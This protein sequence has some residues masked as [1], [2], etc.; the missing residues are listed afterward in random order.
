MTTRK[1]DKLPDVFRRPNRPSPDNTSGY[2]RDADPQV[3][4]LFRR[5]TRAGVESWVHTSKYGTKTIGRLSD[6]PYPS[7]RETAQAWNRSVDQGINPYAALEAKQSAPTVDDLIALW[8]TDVFSTVPP[9]LKPSTVKEYR[10]QI[11]QYIRPAFGKR[12]VTEDFKADIKKL[13]TRITTVGKTRGTPARANRIVSTF[14]MLLS[15]GVKEGIVTDNVARGIERNREEA[16]YRFLNGE[17][18]ERLLTAIGQCRYVQAQ[19]ALRLLLLT[20]SR[21]AEVLGMQW[22]QIDLQAGTWAKPPSATKQKRLH[23]VPLNA[24]ARAILA[25]IYSEAKAREERTGKA[26]SRWLFPA[27]GKRDAPVKEI[28]VAWANVCNRARIDDLHLHDL[29]HVFATFFASTGTGLPLIGRLLGHSQ[30]RT[31]ERYSHVALDPLRT[32]L[33]RFG[34]FVTAVENGRSAEVVEHSSDSRRKGQAA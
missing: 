23:V 24:P 28:R 18:F 14:A 19:R 10:N 16:R 32:E 8:E 31:T 5:T 33:E 15:F 26:M 27:R 12:P 22:S 29:R 34:S 3:R 30:M 25:E 21:R 2:T 7:A 6:W 1:S 17:E 20:G 9:K 13:H 4:G 11:E